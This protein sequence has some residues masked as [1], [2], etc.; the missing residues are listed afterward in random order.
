MKKL[1]LI[2]LVGLILILGGVLAYSNLKA[3][4]PA[5][6]E[7]S[8]PLKPVEKVNLIP[9]EERPYVSIV[10]NQNGRNLVITLHDLKKPAEEAEVEVE[11]QT[12]ELLQGAMLPIDLAK[13]P[14]SVDMLLGSCSAGGKCSYHEDVSGGSLLLRFMGSEKYV[15][16]NDWAFIDNTE[17]ETQFASRDSKFRVEGKGLAR[18]KYAVILQSPGLPENVE[19]RL[20]SAPYAIQYDGSV[21][22]DV[23]VSIRMSEDVTTATI[24]GWDGESWLELKTTVADKVATAV[25]PLVEAYV[26]VE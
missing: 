26:V 5:E 10:P 15:L 14:E 6:D 23:T 7:E 21:T 3:K 18:A 25:A 8:S 13:L 17:Q 9:V 19:R 22:G 11:Y 1:A 20:L 16:K 4:P 12:G 2:G 24:L